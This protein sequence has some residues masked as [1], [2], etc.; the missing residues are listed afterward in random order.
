MFRFNDSIK[1]DLW[2]YEFLKKTILQQLWSWHLK[3]NATHQQQ[4]ARFAEGSSSIQQQRVDNENE[5]NISVARTSS[6]NT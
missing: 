3:I 4:N 5:R 2:K 6:V 1:A